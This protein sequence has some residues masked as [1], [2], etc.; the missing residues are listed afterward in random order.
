MLPYGTEFVSGGALLIGLGAL[1]A[2]FRNLPN[3][4]YALI[5]RYC[6]IRIDI[7]EEDESFQWVKLWLAKMLE[8]SLSVSVFTRKPEAVPDWEDSPAEIYKYTNESG[9]GDKRPRIVFTPA[10]GWYWFMYQGRLVTVNRDRTEPEGKSTSEALRPRESF[11]MRIFSRNL[12]IAKS[13]IEEARDYALPADGK[14]EVRTCS[15]NYWNL[16]GRIRPRPVDSVIL[17]D[18]TMEKI[19]NDIRHFQRSSEWYSRLGVPYRR[20]YLFYGPP[21][22]GKCLAK[23]TPVLMY[24]GTVKMCQDIRSG[25]Q[26]MGPDSKPRNVLGIT[27]G[28]DELY[29]ITPNK[30]EPYVVNKDHIL[31]LKMSRNASY[32]KKGEIVN[33]SVLNYLKMSNSFKHYAK[34]WRTGVD[35]NEQ[36]VDIDPY[37]LGLWLGDGTSKRPEITN[38]NAQI[39]SWI[40]KW[41]DDNGL[42]CKQREITNAICT[43]L[44]Q[45]KATK[46]CNKFIN[47]LRKYNLINNKHIPYVYKVNSRENRLRLL[48]GLIDTDGS[49]NGNCFDVIFKSKQLAQ[50]LVFL[51]RS[52]GFAAYISSCVKTCC[53]NGKVGLYW[54]VGISGNMSEVRCVQE[55]Q[56][57]SRRQIKNV[58]HTGISVSPVGNGEYYGF[59]LDGDGLFLLGDFTVTHNTSLVLS[60]A[61]ELGMNVNIMNLSSP[62]M[63]DGKIVELLSEVDTNTL[64]L[65]EDI[66]CAFAKRSAGTDRKSKMDLGLTFSGVLNALDGILSQDGRIIFMTTNHPEK[67]DPA[68]TR[69]GRAD[70]KIYIGH[71][72]K[73]QAYRLFCR[74][75]PQAQAL[76][77]QFAKAITE[78][79]ISMAKIQHHLMLYRDHPEKAVEQAGDLFQVE[80]YERP[81]PSSEV[82]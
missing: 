26:L 36:S 64:V 76:A 82:A 77:G 39:T 38:V 65:I 75:H 78:G 37:M 17:A 31:S 24:D 50:D 80:N 54:R 11:T 48:A 45:G 4:I 32:Y 33:I 7:Q 14:V 46:G 55:K 67:L 3:K 49:Y 63:N 25:D 29:K 59:E 20:G 6:I 81:Q 13:L 74:F 40:K 30:G 72:T 12:S 1:V 58:L 21:G 15:Q 70:V 62:S 53:N 19:L 43:G 73:D 69:P 5:E 47:F 16:S 9:G 2:Y 10:P 8:G 41:C 22:C 56:C 52:L 66:D 23:D 35:F 61:S 51:C 79:K 57:H 18:N 34:G 60:V 42:V 27:Q 44:P 71:A 68:L 28:T